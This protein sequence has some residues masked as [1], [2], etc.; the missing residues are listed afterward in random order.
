MTIPGFAAEAALYT[1]RHAYRVINHSNVKLESEVHPQRATGPFGPI[2]LPGQDCF[3]A[4]L[5]ICMMGPRGVFFERCMSSCRSTCGESI[6]AAYR[7]W[8]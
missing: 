7:N 6:G 3:G 8:Q 1:A 5:H 4:C 2:G